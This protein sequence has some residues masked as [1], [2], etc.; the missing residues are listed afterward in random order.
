M[1]EAHLPPS[2]VADDPLP[3]LLRGLRSDAPADRL[4]AAKDLARLG[5]LAR[6]ALPAL[7]GTLND[8]D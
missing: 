1:S 7:V 4:R 8:E 5:W 2:T 3:D 6:E